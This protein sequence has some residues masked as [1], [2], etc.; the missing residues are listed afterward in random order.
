MQVLT[1]ESLAKRV[2]Y[3]AAKTYSTQHVL[4]NQAISQTTGLS[5]EEIQN[6]RS[7]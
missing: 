7:E 2:I 6:L 3:N 1:I 5:V 4:D